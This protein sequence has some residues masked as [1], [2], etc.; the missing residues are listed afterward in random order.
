MLGLYIGIIWE[1]FLKGIGSSD[2]GSY[3]EATTMMT[4]RRAFPTLVHT[5]AYGY[6]PGVE[7]KQAF[8]Q[9]ADQE[10]VTIV[11]RLRCLDFSYVVS[12]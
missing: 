6:Q 10:H 8:G 4:I 5:L 7:L 11:R 1:P 2:H 9:I 12:T 3:G